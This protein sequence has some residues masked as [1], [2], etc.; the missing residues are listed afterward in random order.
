MANENKVFDEIYNRLLGLGIQS[1]TELARLLGVSNAAVGKAKQRNSFPDRWVSVISTR[2]GVTP[3]WILG[4]E[5][6]ALPSTLNSGTTLTERLLTDIG[7]LK[8]QLQYQEGA[9]QLMRDKMDSMCQEMDS[10]KGFKK[11]LP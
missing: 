10:L 11:K 2:Y 3:E 7:E 8:V 9:M 1:Q 4:I 5:T 6:R